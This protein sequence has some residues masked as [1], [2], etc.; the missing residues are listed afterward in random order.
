MI[1]TQSFF[2]EF[3]ALVHPVD[4]PRALQWFKLLREKGEEAPDF[5]YRPINQSK[6]KTHPF[7]YMA[8]PRKRVPMKFYGTVMQRHCLGMIAAQRRQSISDVVRMMV[9]RALKCAIGRRLKTSS[10][11]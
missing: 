1:A 2:D 6:I 8:T 11:E 3:L 7:G 4:R 5:S 9:D 10:L